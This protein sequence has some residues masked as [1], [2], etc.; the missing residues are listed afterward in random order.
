[1]TCVSPTHGIL[2]LVAQPGESVFEVIIMAWGM[3]HD[4][5]HQSPNVL[6]AN[7]TLDI[8]V[9]QHG[10]AGAQITTPVTTDY[11]PGSLTPRAAHRRALLHNCCRERS[12]CLPQYGRG[13]SKAPENNSPVLQ[14]V[15]N[16]VSG[17]A[18]KVTTD[19]REM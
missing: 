11:T 9:V 8:I 6:A 12:R 13:D 4:D 2:F 17:D 7:I 16:I 1:M 10:S 3:L 14:T 5:I 18:S 19:S 15:P